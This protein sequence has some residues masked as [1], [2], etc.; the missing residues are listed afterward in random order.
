MFARIKLR[1]GIELYADQLSCGGEGEC[2]GLRRRGW[3]MA[4]RGCDGWWWGG[5]WK[6][7]MARRGP[8]ESK[9]LWTYHGCRMRNSHISL[10]IVTWAVEQISLMMNRLMQWFWFTQLKCAIESVFMLYLSNPLIFRWNCALGIV[11]AHNL[12]HMCVSGVYRIPLFAFHHR[13]QLYGRY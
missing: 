3:M 10:L 4:A 9:G 2:W 7:V 13:N 12:W 8:T 1:R 5:V 6:V 11:A